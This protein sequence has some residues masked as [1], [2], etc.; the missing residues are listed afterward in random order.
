MLCFVVL[1]VVLCFFYICVFDCKCKS[2]KRLGENIQNIK[3]HKQNK[4]NNSK[5]NIQQNRNTGY[6]AHEPPRI[7]Q[8]FLSRRFVGWIYNIFCHYNG[9]SGV[10]AI[11]A[12]ARA[13]ALYKTADKRAL[14]R[15]RLNRGKKSFRPACAGPC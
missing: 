6:P 2:L 3:K 13:R 7:N 1:R 8:T 4:Q 11:C 14:E 5:E 9:S 10:R 12:P 15:S